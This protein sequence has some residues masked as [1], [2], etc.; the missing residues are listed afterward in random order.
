MTLDR[1]YTLELK[2]DVGVS[3][4]WVDPEAG[5][6]TVKGWTRRPEVRR[7]GP[8]H[9][10]VTDADAWFEVR[11]EILYDPLRLK[12]PGD[13][14]TAESAA[15]RREADTLRSR[16]N[17]LEKAGKGDAALELRREADDVLA[18]LAASDDRVPVPAALADRLR[19][20]P[21]HWKR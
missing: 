15:K 18:S 19:R 17:D 9:D 16:A 10:P 13:P 20:V 21:F 6:L 7:G 14:E 11:P 4:A 12:V 3:K 5:E 2:E 1:A 8:A